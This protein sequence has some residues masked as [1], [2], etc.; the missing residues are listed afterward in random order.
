MWRTHLLQIKISD[1]WVPT[2][3]GERRRINE[4]RVEW[5][6]ERKGGTFSKG[7]FWTSSKKCQTC[8][9]TFALSLLPSDLCAEHISLA[10]DGHLPILP[11]TS[12]T[13]RA[14]KHSRPPY[15]CTVHTHLNDNSCYCIELGRIGRMV[16][17]PFLLHAKMKWSS[18]P[19]IDLGAQE[20]KNFRDLVRSA[21]TYL[22][23]K[24]SQS[25]YLNIVCR[26]L[27]HWFDLFLWYGTWGSRYANCN[28]HR[29][30]VYDFS[31]LGSLDDS[32]LAARRPW[33][34]HRGVAQPGSQGRR[35]NL[36]ANPMRL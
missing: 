19:L 24:P 2:W 32:V 36:S 18:V 16:A 12:S 21:V 7:T 31:T 8:S 20:D 5:K 10:S 33:L 4:L 11:S 30:Q 25:T 22:Q 13:S 1:K 15:L 35:K 23:L 34:H 6:V 17:Q 26:W 29:V 27:C 28:V 9:S 3:Q 14:T